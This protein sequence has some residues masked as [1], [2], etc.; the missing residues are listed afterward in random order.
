MTVSDIYKFLDVFFP[1]P[2]AC[3]WD[4][5]GLLIGDK[6][7]TVTKAIIAL[8]CTE[9]VLTEAETT[10]A[11]LIITHHPVIFPDVNSVLS[12]S[13]VHRLIKNGTSVI[14][15]HTNLDKAERGVNYCLAKHLG[16]HSV[17]SIE[18]TDGFSIRCGELDT[19]FTPDEFVKYVGEK[20]GIIP[21]FC[22]GDRKVKR[23]AVCGG[24][25]GDFFGD[26]IRTGADAYVTADI[27][28]H[29]F[30]EAANRGI[31]LIDGGHFNTEDT[32]I[33]PLKNLLSSHFHEITFKTN[34]NS[35]M[36]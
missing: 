7:A 15:A 12:D 20:L 31:T 35:V 23:V 28:H 4:N 33:E 10:G 19:S 16:L 36:R 24:S 11:E 34:H 27:K 29:I 1:F 21:R 18:A 14:S 2:T 32:V 22:A 25:G 17:F 30:L 3:E 8:D 9:D 5:S 13:I 6:N 26:A